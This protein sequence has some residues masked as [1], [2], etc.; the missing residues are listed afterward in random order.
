MIGVVFMVANK[1]AQRAIDRLEAARIVT[2]A[3]EA[4]RNRVYCAGAIL[5]VL[6]EPPQT[7][8]REVSRRR[9]RPE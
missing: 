7:S 5:E 8:T 1:T 3:S 6:E 4:K 2:L 9:R